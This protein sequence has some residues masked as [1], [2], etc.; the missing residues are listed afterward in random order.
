V[1]A[2]FH[3]TIGLPSV[4]LS[5]VLVVV[6]VAAVGGFWPAAA[7]SLIGFLAANWFFTPPYH[8]LAIADAVHLLDLTIF[9]AV[10]GVTGFYVS[11]AARRSAEAARVRAGGETLAALAGRV[12]D[13][14]DPLPVLIQRFRAGFGAD[15]AALLV[16]D[17]DGWRQ[18]AA[19]GPAAPTTP[20]HGELAIPVGPDAVVAL[21]G[22]DVDDTDFDLLL[23][24]A[25]QL[26][27]A[28]E[29]RR[30][31]A[32]AAAAEQ[33]TQVNELRAGLLAAVSHDLRT[34]LASIRTAASTLRLLEGEERRS[35]REE[36]LSSVEEESDRLSDLVSNLVGMSRVHAGA[37]QLS[38]TRIGLDEVVARALSGLPSGRG[39][40]SLEI[41]EGL[42]RVRA[43]AGLLERAVANVVDNALKWSPPGQPVRVTAAASNGRVVLQVADR[44]PGIPKRDRDKVFQPFQRLGDTGRVSGLGLG[45]A[46]ARGF[47]ELMGGELVIEDTP[48]GGATLVA[49]LPEA[50]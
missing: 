21:A 36:L 8:R 4:L 15:A 3:D 40:V 10:A 28:L 5:F 38:I 42:P 18:E 7:A 16:R 17:Q 33:L 49:S 45:L 22:S 35:E 20:D 12:G 41:D 6:L 1:L 27:L 50:P 47:V 25:T 39:R 24:S 34:P 44:G 43:D 13:E 26:T 30:L 9:L 29:R 48:G 31:R 11:M 46:V 2:Q 19:A 14:D 37:V 23:A 32:E